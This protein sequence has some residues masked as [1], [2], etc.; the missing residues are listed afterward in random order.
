MKLN[1][2]AAVFKLYQDEIQCTDTEWSKPFSLRTIMQQRNKVLHW[3]YWRAIT[4]GVYL[5]LIK[6]GM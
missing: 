1:K 5:N 4:F 2:S 3:K 6:E